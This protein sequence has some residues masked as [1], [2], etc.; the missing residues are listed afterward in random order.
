M[1]VAFAYLF[2]NSSILLLLAVK[3]TVIGNISMYILLRLTFEM[4]NLH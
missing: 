4:L 3:V 2:T 1:P